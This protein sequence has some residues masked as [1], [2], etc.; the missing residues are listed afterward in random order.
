[1]PEKSPKI[2]PF[3]PLQP[4]IPGVARGTAVQE[5]EPDSG[6]RAEATQAP[7]ASTKKE[8]VPSYVKQIGILS[9]AILVIAIAL[10]L[11]NRKPARVA[12]PDT[13][14]SPELSGSVAP[15]LPA[16]ERFPSGPGPVASTADL[17]K[18]WSAAKFYFKSTFTGAMAPAMVLHLPGGD[19]WA[20]SLEEP[21]GTCKMEFVT[22]LKKLQTQYNFTADH[23]MV[24]DPCNRSVF[25]LLRYGSGPSGLVRGEVVQG[26]AIRPPIAIEVRVK[27]Q[28]IEAVRSE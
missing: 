6:P 26:P 27:G 5:P 18:P 13:G 10:V 12:A 14:V 25:D 1:M 21:F 23:P 20:F 16:P 7:A 11:W 15:V 24:V 22:D 4:Q 28:Q 19:Y 8:P 3:K 17:A 9:A 2:D